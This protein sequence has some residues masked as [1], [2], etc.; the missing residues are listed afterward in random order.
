ML[1]NIKDNVKFDVYIGRFNKTYNVEQSIWANP[2]VIGKDGSRE[3]VIEKYRLWI[4]SQPELLKKLPEIKGK[5][6]ACW[7]SPTYDC[8]GRIL[9]ELSSSKNI[10]NWFSNMLPM[11]VPLIYDN[12]Q[13]LTVENFYQAMKVPQSNR[14]LR[15]EFAA[16]N[17]FEAKKQVRDKDKCPWRE[18]WSKEMSLRVMKFALKYKFGPGTS[19]HRKLMLTKDLGLEVVEWN[20]WRD[21]F[22]GK[23]LESG[24]GENHLGKILMK[25]RG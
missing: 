17:P 23:S 10:R 16:M 21:L 25:I 11:D 13:Y 19:W 4:N 22:W 15:L 24:L 2:F 20:N 7:C 3:E 12:I 14:I 9:E 5:T 1:V 18:D 6:L 8:H